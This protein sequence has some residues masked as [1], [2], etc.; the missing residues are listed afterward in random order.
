MFFFYGRWPYAL[1]EKRRVPI[2]PVFRKSLRV[3]IV[4]LTRDGDIRL[5]PDR[6]KLPFS[7]IYEVITDRQGRIRIP[8][9]IPFDL[10]KRVEWIGEGKYLELARKN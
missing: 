2:P 4:T 1:D 8:S 9:Q 5:Y 7:E 3:G 6:G 10:G